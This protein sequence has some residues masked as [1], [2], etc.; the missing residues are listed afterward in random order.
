MLILKLTFSLCKMATSVSHSGVFVD[1]H[2]LEAEIQQAEQEFLENS[3]IEE[4]DDGEDFADPDFEACLEYATEVTVET[5]GSDGDEEIAD[6]LTR[7]CGCKKYHNEQCSESFSCKEISDYQL[8]IAELDRSEL[9][10]V[11]IA[12]LHA[13]MNSEELL[14]N[15][16]GVNRP[17]V[18]RRITFTYMFKGRSICRE[19]LSSFIRLAGPGFI[20]LHITLPLMALWLVSM[21]IRAKSLSIPVHLMRF[22]M[23]LTS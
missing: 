16:W 8:A 17:E 10:M 2:L 4:T 13:G 22:L 7:G 12:Q 21:G 20:I 19:C 15:T 14:T 11:L 5:Q 6:F 18:R 23:L 9:D 1:D 3:M